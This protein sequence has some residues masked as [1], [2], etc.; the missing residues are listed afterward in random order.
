MSCLHLTHI[1]TR[2]AIP[3]VSPI[4]PLAISLSPRAE[5]LLLRELIGSQGWVDASDDPLSAKRDPIPLAQFRP[6]HWRSNRGNAAKPSECRGCRRFKR[7]MH[8]IRREASPTR[9]L[10]H[11]FRL[12]G[13]I[14]ASISKP[15]DRQRRA[16]RFLEAKRVRSRP[17][18]TNRLQLQTY[19]CSCFQDPPVSP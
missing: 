4:Q 12:S 1:V 3:R 11:S 14:E 6:R 18:S 17:Q 9:P 15:L 16:S 10:H 7:S 5:S 19:V 13:P 2:S 8:M